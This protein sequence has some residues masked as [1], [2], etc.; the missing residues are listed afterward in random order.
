VILPVNASLVAAVPGEAVVIDCEGS[1]QRH[2]TVRARSHSVME[3]LTLASGNA[4]GDG[5]CVL[6]EAGARLE[7][8]HSK[9]SNCRASGNGGG[10]NVSVGGHLRAVNCTFHRCVAKRNGGAVSVNRASLVLERSEVRFCEAQNGSAVYAESSDSNKP[11]EIVVAGG[12]YEGNSAVQNGGMAFV[13]KSRL[14]V[15]DAEIFGCTAQRGGA[16][17]AQDYS[18]VIVRGSTIRGNQVSFHGGAL[19]GHT[20]SEFRLSDNTSFISNGAKIDSGVA[21]L[22]RQSS[23]YA[24]DGVRFEENKA[25]DDG[26]VISSQGAQLTGPTGVIRLERDVVFMKNSAGDKGGV[27]HV[28]GKV[29]IQVYS[30]VEFVDNKADH[31][32]TTAGSDDE[33]DGKGGVFYVNP[34]STGGSGSIDI[35]GSVVFRR[36]FA[37]DF[38]GVFW[39]SA[40]PIAIRGSVFF[41]GNRAD[42][43]GGVFYLKDASSGSVEGGVRFHQNYGRLA[44]GVATVSDESAFRISD[45]DFDDNSASSDFVLIDRGR[46]GTLFVSDST[47]EIVRSTFRGSTAGYAGAIAAENSILNITDNV[48]FTKCISVFGGAMWVDSSELHMQRDVTMRDNQ[49]ISAGGGIVLSGSP[50]SHAYISRNVLFKRNRALSESEGQGGAILLQGASTLQVWDTV[51]FEDNTASRGGAIAVNGKGASFSVHSGVTFRGNTASSSGGAVWVVP[52]FGIGDQQIIGTFRHG[53]L[54]QNNRALG[55]GGAI[56]IQGRDTVQLQTEGDVQIL[57]NSAEDNGGGIH[58]QESVVV[59]LGAGTR[60]TNNVARYGGG[61]KLSRSRLLV[62]DGDVV[63]I[64]N[65]ATMG[66]GLHLTTFSEVHLVGVDISSNVV[67]TSNVGVGGAGFGAGI[68]AFDGVIVLSRCRL[69]GNNA[70]LGGGAVSLVGGSNF[71]AQNC[72]FNGNSVAAGQGGAVL[73]ANTLP[74]SFSGCSFA[75]NSARAGPECEAINCGSGGAV[76]VTGNAQVLIS[77]SRMQENY[78][79]DGPDSTVSVPNVASGAPRSGG[80]LLLEKAAQATLQNVVLVQNRAANNGGGIAVF[81]DANVVMLGLVTLTANRAKKCGGAMFLGPK[82]SGKEQLCTIDNLEAHENVAEEGSGGAIFSNRP[83]VFSAV[84]RTRLHRN[85]AATEGGALALDETEI[86][87]LEGHTL[88]AAYNSAK[89]NG[90]A[91]ALLRGGWISAE[92][93]VCDGSCTEAMRGNGICDP[94]CLNSACNW[95]DGDCNTQRFQNAGVDARQDCERSETSEDKCSAVN[96]LRACDQRCFTASCDFSRQQ[97]AQEKGQVASCPVLDAVVFAAMTQEGPPVS[98]LAGG[99]SQ[100]YG[101]CR[102]ECEQPVTPPRAANVTGPGRAGGTALALDGLGAWLYLTDLDA[103]MSHVASANWTVEMWTKVGGM[104]KIDGNLRMGLPVG[105]ILAGSNFAVAMLTDPGSLGNVSA[106]PL[107]FAGPPPTSACYGQDVVLR[108]STGRIG[109]GPGLV[110][111]VKPSRCSWTIAPP[112]ARSLTL[113]FTEFYLLKSA[114]AYFDYVEV[115]MCLDKV[116]QSLD[117]CKH[118]SGGELPP[119]LT[120]TTGV[121]RVILHTTGLSYRTNPGFTAFYAAAYDTERLKRDAW[122][123]LAVTVEHHGQRADTAILRVYVDGSEARNQSFLW[124][125]LHPPPFAGAFGTAIGR[126]SPNWQHNHRPFYTTEESN[127]ISRENVFWSTWTSTPTPTG[128]T[129]TPNF[130]LKSQTRKAAPSFNL[131]RFNGSLDDLRVWQE[132]R[133]ASDIKAGQNLAC[134]EVQTSRLAACYSFEQHGETHFEDGSPRGRVQASTASGDSP[135]RPWCQIAIDDGSLIHTCTGDCGNLFSPAVWG[136]CADKLRL[137]GS[138]FDYNQTAMRQLASQLAAASPANTAGR[139]LAGQLLMRFP[140]CGSLPFNISHNKAGAHGGAV[141]VDGCR[142]NRRCFLDGL[143]PLSGTRASIFNHN[144]AGKGGG[145]LFMACS[146]FSSQ[147]LDALLNGSLPQDE[148]TISVVNNTMGCFPSLPRHWFVGNAAAYGSDVASYPARLRLLNMNQVFLEA[149]LSLVPG[150]QKLEIMAD[151]WDSLHTRCK[152]LD[153]VLQVLVCREGVDCVKSSAVSPV[154]FYNVVLETGLIKVEQDFSCPVENRAGYGEGHAP[155]YAVV[156]VSL[157][158]FSEVKREQIRVRCVWCQAG[159]SRQ[160]SADGKTWTCK[161]CNPKEFVMDSNNVAHQCMPCPAQ[162]T[163]D[164]KTMKPDVGTIGE[165]W[166]ADAATG[167]YMLVGCPQ[168][169]SLDQ[170]QTEKR[171]APCKPGTYCVG[172]DKTPFVCP[173]GSHSGPAAHRQEDCKEAFMVLLT[174][175]MP[176]SNPQFIARVDIF[177]DSIAAAASTSID[178]VNVLAVSQT[179]FQRRHWASGDARPQHGERRLRSSGSP[180]GRRVDLQQKDDKLFKANVEIEVQVAA[181]SKEAAKSIAGKLNADAVN[182]ELAMRGLPMASVLLPARLS[183]DSEERAFSPE[184][185]AMIVLPVSVVLLLAIFGLWFW[186]RTRAWLDETEMELLKAVSRVRSCLGLTREKGFFMSNETPTWMEHI[187]RV[188]KG[189]I[190]K[191][192]LEALARLSMLENFETSH[193]D[194]LALAVIDQFDV[195]VILSSTTSEE[196]NFLAGNGLDLESPPKRKR[197]PHNAVYEALC[198]LLLDTCEV[199]LSTQILQHL[200]ELNVT[201]EQLQTRNIDVQTL[202]GSAKLL[203]S[204]IHLDCEPE[205][206]DMVLCDMVVSEDDEQ[207]DL[208]FSNTAHRIVSPQTFNRIQNRFAKGNQ[209][210]FQTSDN[211]F[212]FLRDRILNLRI[213]YFNDLQLFLDLKDMVQKKMDVYASLCHYKYEMLQDDPHGPALKG[214]RSKS[215][216]FTRQALMHLCLC[217]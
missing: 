50:P 210:Y 197:R 130:F 159:E 166:V 138:G 94:L 125:S 212:S 90:G 136:F 14:N 108:A 123:H 173:A 49:A 21:H 120:S 12:T 91:I 177:R 127:D 97:C 152:Q 193:V 139:S 85:E 68:Y 2:F 175:G 118:F 13:S 47:V 39:L 10:I 121:M 170:S 22:W 162:A 178:N 191:R 34:T 132:V 117:E 142:E 11:S 61:V 134:A 82:Y 63:L 165:D 64:A 186:L 20:F 140:G 195:E 70:I 133:A 79:E 73:S 154:T 214:L 211:R 83:L 141:Y 109:D 169:Y 146:S 75:G 19:Y 59:T 189:V 110:P 190:E 143:G 202:I 28:M 199:L 80:A 200:D 107:V 194:A 24:S 6:V 48:H 150:Q 4:T 37:S 1:N 204:N 69:S 23:L 5:G 116:C 31:D 167:R 163:C 137:P 196:D 145:A 26:G 84:G 156:K 171:C 176:F 89:S 129:G 36:N 114:S 184:I 149:D 44:G 104:Q 213:W 215:V 7:L 78:A 160:V 87:L 207:A 57:F 81:E 93:R 208:E 74:T 216:S 58:A 203:R 29:T 168:G 209:K 33:G 67:R 183:T 153:D 172:G 45:V 65:N 188:K 102:G 182:S 124:D 92:D 88:E 66:A 198:S 103:V 187:R 99:T 100:E 164:G 144:I 30:G 181:A 148:G 76:A 205:R 155:I 206:I 9:L 17:W 18:M 35:Q 3:G 71:T 174:V 192:Y 43:S 113:L 122:H 126:G 105:F 96:Q 8:R 158:R 119:T 98:S 201:I 41:G 179:A 32:G 60:I 77:D 106:W 15:T 52:P 157:V 151:F 95:D 27:C 72:E 62:P 54:F 55:D 25:G 53:V 16:L 147:C 56:F 185:F 46:G 40:M 135:H 217:T 86:Q 131:G 161:K 42:K 111:R 112:G 180:P 101:W 51:L 38:G 115:C 128:W